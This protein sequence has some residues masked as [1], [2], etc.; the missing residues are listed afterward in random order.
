[1]PEKARADSSSVSVA[2]FTGGGFPGR[3]VPADSIPSPRLRNEGKTSQARPGLLGTL[4]CLP[5]GEELLDQPLPSSLR[6][7]T[8][9]PSILVARSAWI[10][11]VLSPGSPP[12]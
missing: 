2:Q 5:I 12:S 1:R 4:P 3:P 11:S 7:V 8:F 6:T 10:T 9:S